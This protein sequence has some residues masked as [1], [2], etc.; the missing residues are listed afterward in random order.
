MI[1]KWKMAVVHLECAT[2]SVDFNERIRQIDDLHKS[3]EESKISQKEFTEK[4]SSCSRDIRYQG[5]AIFLKNEGKHYLLTARHVLWD[6]LSATRELNEGIRRTQTDSRA[7]QYFIESSKQ[8]ALDKIFSIIF[9]VPSLNEIIGGKKVKAFLMNLGAGVPYLT[10]YTFSDQNIDLAIIS[11]DQRNNEF[12]KELLESGYEPISLADISDEPTNEGSDLM[13][14]GFPSATSLIG[15]Q[16]L[17]PA[18]IQWASNY[19]SLPVL[20][21][22]RVS[23]LHKDL[24]FFWADMSIYPGNSGGPVIENDKLVGIVSA[25]AIIPIENNDE[26]ELTARIPFG[27]IIKAK[28]IRELLV[29]QINKDLQF[30]N[31]NC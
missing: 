18:H 1:D 4:I 22:G 13:A 30:N 2:D 8:I 29:T 21:F 24:N 25:Q 11:L 6:E 17:H 14:V 26:I 9:R 31:F 15:Q 3:L 5:T 19:F 16:K 27:K 23:L 28:Y 7:H 10:P 20:S 12:T